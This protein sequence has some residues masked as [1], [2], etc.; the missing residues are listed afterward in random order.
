[1]RMKLGRLRTMLA[2]A[3]APGDEARDAALNSVDT[4]I[5]RLDEYV[6]RLHKLTT[7]AGFLK[8]A[9]QGARTAIESS[10]DVRSLS[11][12]IQAI[13]EWQQ[14]LEEA[15]MNFN[16]WFMDYAKEQFGWATNQIT[17][18]IGAS[19]PSPSVTA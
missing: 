10:S 11:S 14:G 16:T 7:R 1:M 5:Y 3:G 12:S 2:E 9:L 4:A 15:H 8:K 18:L 6:E 19:T 13:G 17:A